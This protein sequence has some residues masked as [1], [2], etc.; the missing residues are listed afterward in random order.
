MSKTFDA[1][2][3]GGHSFTAGQHSSEPQGVAV[4]A[5]RIAAVASDDQLREAGATEVIE[6]N[7]GLVMPA[8]H[9]AHAH[10]I[11]AGI[12]LLECD[13]TGAENSDEAIKLIK[14]FATSHAD[15]EWIRGGGWSLA[16]FPGGTPTKELLD[17][18]E[19]IGGRPVAILNRDHHG[20]WVNSEALKR[21][22][23][24]LN[25]SDP[26][27][28][29]IERKES[30][31]PSGV[32]HEG[33]MELIQSVIPPLPAQMKDQGLQIAQQEYFKYGIAG[34][35]DA[36][37]GDMPGIG[38]NFDAYFEAA[39][40]GRLQARVT[41]ALW[42]DRNRGLEQI[43]ELA[44]KRERVK[45]LGLE[46]LL[47]ADTIKVMV[48]GIPENFTAAISLPY[49]DQQG[50]A[51]H[52]HGLT[53][54]EPEKLT[55]TVV[56]LDDAGFNV[57]F[58]S[59]GD[60]A[61]TISLDAVEAAIARNGHRDDRRHHL[62]HLQIVQSSDVP[63]FVKTGSWANM[64]MLWA[65]VDDQLDELTFPFIDESLVSRHYPFGDLKKAGVKLAAGS[66]WPVSTQNPIAAA[67]V[68][69]NRAAPGNTMD[70]R[71]GEAQK[72]TLADVFTA[73]T[74]GSA[75]VNGRKSLTG[76]LEPGLLAD[77]IVLDRDP[78][79]HPDEEIYLA[80]VAQLSLSGTQVFT[81]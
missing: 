71:L 38:D 54:L 5:G 58:H 53:F 80:E 55:D 65:A 61:V 72:L 11:A 19:E 68:G 52:N 51:T 27:D 76:Q 12:E 57:H 20:M 70:P 47:I 44:E 3:V 75:E 8:F 56:A 6:L 15:S 48:D 41:A 37:V 1:I 4:K 33:A 34:W 73:Y 2:Y 17:E 23:I 60:R 46:H 78:F 63:R 64:Q 32:L 28:G 77:L 74:A 31:E 16:H 25:T 21:A 69:V 24:D 81:R 18:L 30:G 22:G 35:Q 67:H 62:A 45:K 50:C 26:E 10:P 59:L 13:L 79:Q 49:K 9:D 40:D 7:G 36:W 29:R 42:W 66:D 14:K 39:V 43:P